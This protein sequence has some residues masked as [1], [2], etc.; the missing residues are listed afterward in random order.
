MAR[1]DP[2]LYYG[3]EYLKGEIMGIG[4]DGD[5]HLGPTIEA[6]ARTIFARAILTLQYGNFR[7]N[8]RHGRNYSADELERMPVGNL[9][10]V[11][12]SYEVPARF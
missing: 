12:R 7:R 5:S 2:E 11:V 9:A 1:P 8:D 4:E 3:D 10:A 6:S